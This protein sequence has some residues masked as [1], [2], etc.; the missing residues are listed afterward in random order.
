MRQC[1]LC[2]K[3]CPT[4]SIRETHFTIDAERC[5]TYLNENDGPFPD[6][7][8]P[9]WHNAI[10]G[11]MECQNA[12][13]QNKDLINKIERQVDFTANETATILEKTPWDAL[14][15]PLRKKL[16]QLDMTEYY[17]VLARNLKVLM[18]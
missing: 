18:G 6:W 10:V 7:V 16:D 2:L 17:G 3:A 1:R 11:C 8:D 12:C 9:T 14:P 13:P 4:G 15:K 5:L